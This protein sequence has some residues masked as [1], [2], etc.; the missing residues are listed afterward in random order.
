VTKCALITGV[1]GQEGSYL[2]EFLLSKGYEVHG[3]MRRSSS[4]NTDRVDHLHQDPNE[5]DVRFHLHH[6]D[7][8]DGGSFHKPDFTAKVDGLDVIRRLETPAS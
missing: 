5:P 3:I 6:G 1:T 4:F 2:S 8:T 7:L